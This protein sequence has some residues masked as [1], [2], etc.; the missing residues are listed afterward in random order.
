MSCQLF[1][2]TAA[3]TDWVTELKTGQCRGSYHQPEPS[4]LS[5]D[6]VRARANSALHVTDHSTTLTGE[7]E[8][9]RGDLQLK[10]DFATIDAETEIYTAEGSVQL[11]QVDMLLQGERMTGNLFAGTASIDSASFLLHRSRVRGSATRL[12]KDSDNNLTIESGEFTTCEPGSNTWSV[13]GKS[14]TLK[15]DEG[16]GIARDVTLSIKDVPVAY[17]PWF[18]FPIDDRRQSGFLMPNI[19]RDSDGGTDITIPYYFNLKPNLDATYTLRNLHKRG[20]M[21]EGEIRYLNSSSSNVLAATFL[22]SDDV[23]DDRELIDTTS[24][25]FDEQNRWLAHIDHH[26]RFGRW[27][28]RINFTSVS[29]TDYF[30]DIGSFTNTKTRFDRA[31]GQSDS[32]AI[33][34]TG[35]LAYDHGNW[36]AL[37]ELRSFQEL[38]QQRN[39]QY[40]VLPRLTVHGSRNLARVKLASRIQMTEFDHSDSQPTGSRVVVD[41]DMRLPFRKPWGFLTP[42]LRVIY[43]DYNLDD[44]ITPVRDS[45]SLTTSL[46]SLDAGLIFER[47]TTIRGQ[48]IRQTLEPRF[49]YL[50]AEED[51]QDD[52]P[53]FDSTPL[54]S[55]YDNLFRDTRFTGYDRVGDANQIALGVS[56]SLFSLNGTR[57]LSASIGQLF[58]LEDREV[59]IGLTPGV[60]PAADTSPLFAGINTRYRNIT[61]NAFYEYDRDSRQSNRGFISFKYRNAK[62]AA[63]NVTYTL[64]DTSVQRHR[65]PRNEEETNISFVWPLSTRWQFIGR[66][67]YGW[68]DSETIESLFGVE[69]NDCCWKARIVFRRNLE[70]PRLIGLTTPGSGVRFVTDRRADSGIYFEFQLKGLASLGGRLDSLI[71]DSIPGYTGSR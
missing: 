69:Y 10:A 13:A 36:G 44:T 54:T 24:S 63:L 7:I 25:D 3:E 20:L 16:Y 39:E 48:R 21:H 50:Y 8:I 11:R 19:G 67:N 14:I 9:N 51:F 57:L 32:P 34:R 15:N 58:H 30:H 43:R 60:D 66:W 37:L 33:L 70:E 61:V 52:L 17:F 55:S 49:F 29:D 35:S 46:A 47:R 2:N 18:R 64:T 31:L 38:S 62:D 42:A 27:T 28:S 41:S 68:D 26:G 65:L 22:P 1:A 6:T 56:T 4:A 12:A 45:A 71:E 53:S 23:Y 59:N 5:G 40:S